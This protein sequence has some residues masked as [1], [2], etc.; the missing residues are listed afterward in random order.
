MNT[1]SEYPAVATCFEAFGEQ[2]ITSLGILNQQK[3][4]K[5]Q[6]GLPVM[7][8]ETLLTVTSWCL[9]LLFSRNKARETFL[10]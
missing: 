9:C 6:I 7:S 4:V 2:E 8:R 1:F 5:G 10:F 3:V